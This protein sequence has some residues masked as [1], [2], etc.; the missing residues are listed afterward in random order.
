M[1]HHCAVITYGTLLFIE[2]ELQN[3]DRTISVKVKQVEG[4]GLSQLKL[5]RM[6]FTEPGRRLDLSSSHHLG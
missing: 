2:G 3:L 1:S 6:T 5:R 4:L